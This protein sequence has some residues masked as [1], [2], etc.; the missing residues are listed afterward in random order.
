MNYRVVAAPIF[1]LVVSGIPFHAAAQQKHAVAGSNEFSL[2]GQLSN[3]A[4]EEPGV[5]ELKGKKFAVSGRITHRGESDVFTAA[6]ARI[7]YGT[8]DYNSVNT[9]SFSGAPDYLN[10][11]RALVGRRFNAGSS[12]ISP[13]FGVGWR[14]LINDSSTAVSS[15]GHAGF[16]R[17]SGYNYLPIGIDWHSKMGGN[18]IEF[19][20]EY[21]LLLRGTQRSEIPGEPIK[22]TQ[23]T[24]HGFRA[25]AMWGQGHWAAGPFANIWKISDSNKE[26]CNGGTALCW[27]PKNNTNEA[28][29][30]IRYLFQ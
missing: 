24:G 14:Y 10:D 22:N 18:Y 2:E 4:Y 29:I 28:G 27:E 3:Y 15:T 20:A 12:S 7:A 13:Y 8:V 11:F 1:G 25:S 16:R 17:V 5:M 30:R 23:N 26:I 6:E 21:D 19:N 9:G